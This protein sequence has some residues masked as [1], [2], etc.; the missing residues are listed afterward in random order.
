MTAAGLVRAGTAVLVLCALLLAG[1]SSAGG[2]TAATDAVA[3]ASAAPAGD[4]DGTG[5]PEDL[6]A[7]PT[8]SLAPAERARD[9]AVDIGHTAVAEDMAVASLWTAILEERGELV[10]RQLV[11]VESAYEHLADGSLDVYLGARLPRAHG[12]PYARHGDR[13]DDLGPW[14]ESAPLRWAVP[15]YVDVDSIAD[16][17]G[18]G[19]RF[20]NRVIGV[21]EDSQLMR[22][23]REEVVPTYD[24]EE[25][26]LLSG[27]A[28]DMIAE[29]L[30][31]LE[32]REPVIVTL[33]RPHWAYDELPIKD[34][35]DPRGAFGEPDA[36]HVLATAGFAAQ[37]PERC[38]A[39]RSPGTPWRTSSS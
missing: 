24:L 32:D 3:V 17:R 31:S 34:L 33:W 13:L 14:F 8:A 7:E 10:R 22:L 37:F 9:R 35:E 2:R 21:D 29:L 39:S 38:S 28:S 4:T 27:S 36:I 18:E 20:G 16:L 11:D 30:R 23:S 1:C 15:E 12:D 19:A 5:S 26:T 6:A 25:Y